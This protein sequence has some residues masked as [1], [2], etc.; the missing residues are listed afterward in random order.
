MEKGEAMENFSKT[1]PANLLIRGRRAVVVGGGKVAARKVAGLAETDAEITVVAPEVNALIEALAESGRVSVT[2]RGFEDGDLDGAFLAFAAT[3]DAGL[4]RRVMEA[5]RSRGVLCCAVDSNWPEGDFIKPA[6]FDKGGLSVAVSTHGASCRQAKLVKRNLERHVDAVSALDVLVL[7][8]DHN[9]LSLEERERFHL[10]GRRFDE[11]GGM[12]ARTFGVHE[13]LLLDTC[14]RVELWAVVSPS[15]GLEEMLG[16]LMGFSGCRDDAR[17]LK[18]GSEAFAHSASVAAGLMSQT[19]G[20]KHVVAQLKDALAKATSRG[21]ADSA[22][23]GWA[24][25][26]LMVS[27]RIRVA[28]DDVLRRFEIEDVAL[29]YLVRESGGLSGKRALVVGTGEMGRAIAASLAREGADV[30]GLYRTNEPSG[31]GMPEGVSFKRMN[32]LKEELQSAD[33]VV[34]AASAEAPLLHQGHAPF[35][36]SSKRIFIVDLAMPRNVAPELSELMPNAEVLDLDDLKYWRRRESTDMARVFEISKDV[37]EGNLDAFAK[38]TGGAD[39][40][41]E[42]D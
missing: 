38:I 20:E 18:R 1:Y 22:I 28:I 24:D 16:F 31:E 23:R 21:W 35:F 9:Y 3:G 39:G 37:I 11:V 14:N 29:E 34:C 15:K 8:T 36:D 30:V 17:Y 5:C 33:I 4:N 42:R 13:F 12:V 41:G 26:A 10:A 2:R 32:V 19:P 7:G 40:G 27:K 6:C 25:A